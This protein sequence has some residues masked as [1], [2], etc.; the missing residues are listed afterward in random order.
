MRPSFGSPAVRVRLI[1]GFASPSHDGFAVCR[2]ETPRGEERSNR[3]AS[4]ARPAGTGNDPVGDRPTRRGP[5]VSPGVTRVLPVRS[6]RKMCYPCVMLSDAPVAVSL[7]FVATVV[8]MLAARALGRGARG[9]RGRARARRAGVRLA[10]V[11]LVG[12]LALTAVLA[13]RGFFEDFHSLPPHMLL[14]GRPAAAGRCSRSPPRG[15]L[16]PAPGRDAP[17]LAGGRADLPHRGRDRA[18]A[19]RGGGGWRRR[20]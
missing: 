12:W 2:E 1:R 17:V 18:V 11:A 16:D 20:S 3:G 10:G 15:R 19:A 4:L 6:M 9:P 13:D 14:G 5:G 7:L 8:G